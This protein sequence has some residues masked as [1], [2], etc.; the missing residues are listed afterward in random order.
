MDFN[1]WFNGKINI[2]KKEILKEKL[3]YSYA[4]FS[5]V[6]VAA[7]AID[8]NGKEYYGVNCENAAYPSGLC[9]ERSALFGSVAYG[10]E[11]GSFQ[12]IHIISNL[13]KLLYPCGACLQ[14][15]SQFLDKNAK[16]ILH[17]TDLLE[18]KSFLIKDLIPG[19]VKP[20]D[21]MPL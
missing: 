10:A 2:M 13:N 4:P 14:V 18:E 3:N 12:E 15:M 11:V 20:E 9:A 21:I 6:K 8:K 16:V 5:K 1:K 7:L 19:A 17:S